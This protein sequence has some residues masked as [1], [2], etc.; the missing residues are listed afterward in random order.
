MNIVPHRRLA[1]LLVLALLLAGWPA[2]RHYRATAET[3]AQSAPVTSHPRLWLTADDLPRLRGW[4]TDSNPM[5]GDGLAVLAEELKADM[6]AGRV[7][8]DDGGSYLWEEYPTESYAEFFAFMSLIDPDETERED[9]AQRART[10]LMQV[11]DEAAKGQT[12]DAPFRDPEFATSDRSR[13]WGESF[14]LTVDWIYS[15]LTT[16]DKATIRQVFLRWAEE[17]QTTG[18]HRPGYVD[19]A[20]IGVVNDPALVSDPNALRW[21]GNNYFTGNMRDLGLMAMALDPADDPDGE[22]R[23]YLEIATGA[24]LYMVDRLF[25]T[26]SAGGFAPEGFEYSPQTIGYDA[27]FLLALE[28]AGQADPAVWGPQVVL[29]DN[30]F[31]DELLPAY[32][33][34]LSPQPALAPGYEYVGPVYQPAWYG[35]G[36][37]FWAPD[38]I[39]AF[40]ALGRYDD[41]T[42]NAGRLDA[43]RWIETNLAPGGAERMI[44]DRVANPTAFLDAIFYFLLF[45]PA[46][47]APA[48][49]RPGLPLTHF[50]PGIGRLLARTGWDEEAAWF[51]YALGWN[52]VDHQHGNGNGFEFYRDGEWLTKAVVG[53]GTSI[54]SPEET[55][56]FPSSEYQNTLA[57]END[58][59]QYN[60]PTDPRH[61][62]WLRGSQWP[63]DP[64][65]D[66][67]ILAMSV[68]PGYVY[69]LGDATPL[70]NSD[71]E[72]MLDVRH[73]SRSIVWLAPDVIVVYDRAS[74]AT[75]GRFKR[76]WLNLPSPARVEGNQTTMT[77]ASGQQLA[78]TTLLPADAVP[79]VAPLDIREEDLAAGEPMRYRLLVEAP[80]GPPDARF[81]HV[82]QGVDAGAAAADAV[83]VSSDDGSYAGTVVGTT[84]V[85]FP[86][87][88]GTEV[89]ALTYAVPAE[90]T[91]H[92]ITG[93]T[94]GGEYDVATTATDDGLEVRVMPG[95]SY[96]ADG[97]GVL[98]VGSLPEVLGASS[99]A[100]TNSPAPLPTAGT[101]SAAPAE[102]TPEST[103]AEEPATPAPAASPI[104][105][106]GAAASGPGQIAYKVYDG[107]VYRVAAE[108]GATP[109][110]VSLALDALSP[111][112][113][114]DGMSISSDG[115]W[116]L[117]TTERFDP[118]CTGWA[119]LVVVPADLSSG[120]PV[121]VEG[122]VV[123]PEGYSAIA[124]GGDL[125]VYPHSGGPH[126]LDLWVSSRQDGGWSAPVLL[127]GDSPYAY[128]DYPAI[129]ADGSRLVFDCGDVPY[130]A[131]GT[132]ICEV[133]L[134]GSG[135]RVVLT[136]ADAPP[137]QPAT[138]ALHH[139][140]YAPDGSLVFEADW[141]AETIW[142]LPPNAA[143]PE[144]VGPA[145][146]NDNSP[147]VLS[148]GRI[149][150]LWLDRPGGPSL[151]ELKVMTPDG[152]AYVM[153][154][155]GV[156]IE[157][158]GCGG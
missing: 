17:I 50:A 137:G 30:P 45:D 101:P 141:S 126:A 65:G 74:S 128:H 135:F 69:A 39:E 91:T 90:T 32:L 132:A 156:D 104:L 102:A 152:A 44:P 103:P 18:Y 78:V 6:D 107:H 106:G 4:A 123:H 76:F 67:V 12:E 144:P 112:A 120:E 100:F 148:D 143:L 93:L 83:L 142:R 85:L 153:V 36:Q 70:Y 20:L 19:P 47:P 35:D 58:P 3:R 7:P 84:A 92:L 57:L 71:Y 10:L 53:Y 124:S 41:L 134:D 1:W 48:D 146:N 62:L 25:R 87:E 55:Y 86:V 149:V 46:A 121:R 68:A 154:V 73:A 15:A 81:F 80:G 14:G 95:S 5:Y 24:H 125:V 98:V 140:A 31:W 111:A 127:S 118:A 38:F 131:A 105:E 8:G 114:D 122:E 99:F 136:P 129:A 42:G 88:V 133:G 150:S 110:D 158:I 43:L 97:G 139:P 56:A 64:Q 22:L 33:H 23:S 51:I 109:E 52:A 116:L 117:L 54:G 147:C 29:N 13:W 157:D 2:G 145:F 138:G 21:S 61:E 27:Q 72:G 115:Q 96:R 16:E 151:H 9:N 60:D 79:T 108:A 37:A 26:D 63:L 89:V 77:T 28:T 113:P 130:A 82:L 66:P 155:T 59:P 34:S 94:P 40:G 75:D 119:C 49:P 11:L